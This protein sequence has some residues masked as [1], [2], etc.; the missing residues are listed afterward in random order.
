MESHVDEQLLADANARLKAAR[1]RVTIRCRGEALYLRAT[2][3]PK[4]GSRRVKP[5]QYDLKTGLPLSRDGLRRAEAE[6]QHLGSTLALKQF[7]WSDW[8]DEKPP[9][10]R[11]IREWI[12]EFKQHY[13]STH[14]LSETTWAR[15]WQ[16]VYNALPQGGMLVP[17]VLVAIAVDTPPN[18]RKRREFCLKLQKLA[19]FAELELDLKPYQGNYSSTRPQKVRKLPTDEMVGDWLARIKNPAW[20]SF[21]GIVATFGLR[22][23]EFWYCHFID[24]LT[25]QVTEGKTGERQVQALYPEWVERWGLQDIQRP[26]VT[27]KVYRDYG[28][29]ASTQFR[30]Y[31][32]PFSPYDLR[33]AWA[34]RA[35]ITFRLPDTIAARMMGHSVEVHNKTYHRWLSQAKQADVYLAAIQSGPKAPK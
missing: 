2:L 27:A 5:G 32:L 23:H 3:P 18:T 26:N 16:T 28:D 10:E 19:D 9:E 33:H 1:I 24:D 12:G 34:I 6:A 8:L 15:H 31:G 30:R 14:S 25:L 20:H 11:E 22:P 21:Y 35:S 13:M 4:P 29:R 7:E 17:E